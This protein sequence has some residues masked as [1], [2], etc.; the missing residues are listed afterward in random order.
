MFGGSFYSVSLT[1]GLSFPLITTI[2]S[3]S[4]LVSS[5]W[6]CMMMMVA[7]LPQTINKQKVVHNDEDIV[8]GEADDDKTAEQEL[9][10]QSEVRT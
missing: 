1:D 4:Y 6:Q 9:V 3:L 7:C 8:C 5:H 10:N 2:S